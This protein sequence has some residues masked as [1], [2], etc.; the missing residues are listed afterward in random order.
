M[1]LYLTSLIAKSLGESGDLGRQG[2]HRWLWAIG[3]YSWCGL[4]VHVPSRSSPARKT[5][6][7]LCMKVGEIGEGESQALDIWSMGA[8]SV[9]SVSHRLSQTVYP[10]LGGGWAVIPGMAA[11]MVLRGSLASP[12]P[13][14]TT[15]HPCWT[16]TTSQ[17]PWWRLILESSLKPFLQR[18][19]NIRSLITQ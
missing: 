15:S 12:N 10:D 17:E 13:M 19:A 18:I 16:Q 2:Q 9:Q 5:R 1:Y 8:G 14:Q 4:P 3:T 6:A 11:P 7:V